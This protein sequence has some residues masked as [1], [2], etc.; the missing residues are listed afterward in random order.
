MILDVGHNCEEFNDFQ[1]RI[2]GLL[3]I[4]DNTITTRSER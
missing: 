2:F 1:Q 4:T 3:F